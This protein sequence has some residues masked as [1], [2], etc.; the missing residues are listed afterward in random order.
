MSISQVKQLKEQFRTLAFHLQDVQNPAY[1]Y[2]FE[3]AILDISGIGLFYTVGSD[4]ALRDRCTRVLSQ[5]ESDHPVIVK[6]RELFEQEK[7]AIEWS[8]YSKAAYVGISALAANAWGPAGLGV[9]AVGF[10]AYCLGK[11]GYDSMDHSLEAQ[12]EQI[13]LKLHNH[14]S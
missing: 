7:R 4:L 1:K 8:L 12:V 11:A 5:L 2:T 6:G 14:T 13:E 10:G 3:K 9:A